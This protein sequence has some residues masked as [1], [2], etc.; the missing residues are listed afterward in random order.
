MLVQCFC[1]DTVDHQGWRLLT[2]CQPSYCC[3][4][5]TSVRLHV[6]SAQLHPTAT[7]YG[8]PITN[9]QRTSF[10]QPASSHEPV[11]PAQHGLYVWGDIHRVLTSLGDNTLRVVSVEQLQCDRIIQLLDRLYVSI[12][13][14]FDRPKV[15]RLTVVQFII[16]PRTSSSVWPTSR[17]S[18]RH[19][20]CGTTPS[21]VSTRAEYRRRKQSLWSVPATWRR[22]SDTSFCSFRATT[23]R[24][25][26]RCKSISA[27]IISQLV[28]CPIVGVAGCWVWLLIG[29]EFLIRTHELGLSKM[30]ENSN[31]II[32]L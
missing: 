19:L 10:L 1:S 18:W 16:G 21:V 31:F 20:R 11:L 3:P 30:P 24:I 2:S 28:A 6:V 32:G 8:L 25:S 13:W 15:V 17:R 9:R 26:A 12:V 27:V 29:I 22:R 7:L 4:H 23:T 5:A 14:R